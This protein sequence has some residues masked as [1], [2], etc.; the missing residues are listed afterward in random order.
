MTKRGWYMRE[1]YGMVL[2]SLIECP[3]HGVV[4]ATG[5]LRDQNGKMVCI[6]C[7]NDQ[8]IESEKIKYVQHCR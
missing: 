8:C 1:R 5:A 3:I 7:H 2:E 6:K 4:H